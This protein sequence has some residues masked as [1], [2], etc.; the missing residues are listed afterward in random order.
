MLRLVSTEGI[1]YKAFTGTER[2]ASLQERFQNYVTENSALIV[3]GLMVLSGSGNAY[4]TYKMLS[5]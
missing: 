4:T 2:K 5:R 3:S 1:G